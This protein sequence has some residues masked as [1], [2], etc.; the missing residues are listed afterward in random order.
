MEANPYTQ[1]ERQDELLNY[2]KRF[3]EFG[4]QPDIITIVLPSVER[5]RSISF[6][7]GNYPLFPYEVSPDD[8]FTA[9][10]LY[11]MLVSLYGD[12]VVQV[13]FGK[14][15]KVKPHGHHILIGGSPTNLFSFGALVDQYYQ[16]GG[17]GN[18]YIVSRDGDEYAVAFDGDENTP[19]SERSVIRD[20][21]IISK[22]SRHGRDSLEFVLS[23]SRA[24]GQMVFW[25]LLKDINFYKQVLPEVEGKDF[26]I[27]LQITIDGRTCTRWEK[28]DIR[29]G[30]SE[31][32]R[33]G[34][35][36]FSQETMITWLHLSDLHY[37]I[38]SEYD[39]N[40][41]LDALL[42]DVDHL[43][44]THENNL[45]PDFIVV[46]GDIAF[47]SDRAEY[48]KAA[49]FFDDL[50]NIVGLPKSCLFVVP[51]NHDVDRGVISSDPVAVEVGSI[52]NSRNKVNKFLD[53]P[54]SRRLV[55]RRLHNYAHFINEY[56]DPEMTFDDDNYFYVKQLTVGG[57]KL[58]ILGLNSAWLCG[59]DQDRANGILLG[60]RQVRLALEQAESAE[61]RIALLHHPFN[62]LKEFDRRDSAALLTNHCDFILH[63][64][65]HQTGFQ[66]LVTPDSGAM[67]IAAGASYE[68]REYPNTYNFVRLNTEPGRV[69]LRRY[70]DLPPGFW[71]S[72]TLTYKN[73]TDGTLTFDYRNRRQ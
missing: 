26:Q 65:L 49:K 41:V 19:L 3:F 56:F 25:D 35:L 33:V 40:I 15:L 62:W 57:K 29:S 31:D 52:L 72:D 16:F 18:H 28:V 23:G 8:V 14:E 70:S 13:V 66:Q 22:S 10:R 11:S 34:P 32:T 27:L 20:H 64:H 51:G 5:S 39:S 37:R 42:Q 71:A 17:E 4:E 58:A 55:F 21:S 47:S 54:Y 6:A 60:E 46:T 63:G 36:S 24:Y 43:I 2:A 73:A 61:L 30:S 12:D 50:L 1:Y 48:E 7:C 69:I 38:G 53:N 59:S 45:S 44:R 67:I 9:L 68:N